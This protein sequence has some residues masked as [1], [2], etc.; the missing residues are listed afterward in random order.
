MGLQY[1][2]LEQDTAGQKSKGTCK[3][4]E[5]NIGTDRQIAYKFTGSTLNRPK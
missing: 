1:M 5:Y 3:A 4:D 2:L